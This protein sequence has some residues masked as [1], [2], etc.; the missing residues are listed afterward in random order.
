MPYIIGI[1]IAKS[2]HI[3]SAYQRVRKSI[4]GVYKAP[5][6]KKEEGYTKKQLLT[7]QSNNKRG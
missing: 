1:F 3:K 6:A 2:N 5:K 4:H 7:T